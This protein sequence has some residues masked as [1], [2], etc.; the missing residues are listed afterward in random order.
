MT[1]LKIIKR[2][3]G[4]ICWEVAWDNEPAWHRWLVVAIFNAWRAS[5]KNKETK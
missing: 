2:D 3:Y 1:I 5:R 4:N